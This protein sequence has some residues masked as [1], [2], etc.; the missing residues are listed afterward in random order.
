MKVGHNVLIFGPLV[1]YSSEE[2]T[3]LSSYFKAQVTAGH[4]YLLPSMQR[5]YTLISYC[6]LRVVE[7]VKTSLFKTR[8]Q[9]DKT[10]AVLC[11]D[12]ITA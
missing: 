1:G 5:K 7:G 9:V 3:S 6:H 8:R 4:Q 12:H 2:G 10:C 11:I